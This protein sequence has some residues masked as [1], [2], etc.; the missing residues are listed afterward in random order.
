[1]VKRLSNRPLLNPTFL[2]DGSMRVLGKDKQPAEKRGVVFIERMT[3]A[4]SPNDVFVFSVGVVSLI[5]VDGSVEVLK[6]AKAM[7]ADGTGHRTYRAEGSSTAVVSKEDIFLVS[8]SRYNEVPSQ[9][10]LENRTVLNLEPFL[11]QMASTTVEQQVAPNILVEIQEDFVELVPGLNQ[12][13]LAH[14]GL[15]SES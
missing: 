1:M 5:R 7:V 13:V 12:S 15:I 14:L 2:P 9:L 6:F 8:E 3:E 11:E 10:Q 4:G